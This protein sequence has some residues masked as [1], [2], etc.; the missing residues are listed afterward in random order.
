MALKLRSAKLALAPADMDILFRDD[1]G[2]VI[3][4][5][6]GEALSGP[7]GFAAAPE[8]AML[9]ANVDAALDS[10]RQWLEGADIDS[11]PEEVRQALSLVAA[12][13]DGSDALLELLGGE[14]ASSDD[15]EAMSDTP[16]EQFDQSDYTPAQ[17][18]SACLIDKGDGDEDSKE[19]YALPIK[20]PSGKVNKHGVAAAAGRIG[21]VKGAPDDEVKAAARKLMSHYGKMKKPVPPAVLKVMGQGQRSDEELDAE[22]EAARQLLEGRLARHGVR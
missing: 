22:A 6:S 17:W 18:R 21:A 19:R 7:E 4:G 20:E 3:D 9:A 14:R 11:L 13:A 2:V 15:D 5:A 10:A 12:A 8:T 16:W 1:T